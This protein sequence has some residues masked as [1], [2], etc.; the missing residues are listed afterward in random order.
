MYVNVYHLKRLGVHWES[1]HK[2]KND[3]ILVRKACGT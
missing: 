2:L 3:A 1:C